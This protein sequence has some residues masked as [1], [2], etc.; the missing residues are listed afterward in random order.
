MAGDEALQVLNDRIDRARDSYYRLVLLVGP[1][2]SGKTKFLQRFASQ[3]DCCI[4]NLNLELSRRMLELPKSK[5]ARQV[6]RLFKDWIANIPSEPILLDNIEM[7]FDPALRLDPLRLLQ[8]ISRN[9]TVVATWN[10]SI[11]NAMLTYAEPG[12]PEYILYRDAEAAM[13]QLGQAH[14]TGPSH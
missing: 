13:V 9:R 11:H 1:S 8:S 3:H 7:L 14:P 10:G 5:R 4:L 2:N 6:D 12:H